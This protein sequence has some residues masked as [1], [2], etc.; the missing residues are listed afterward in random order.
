MRAKRAES[1]YKNDAG[2]AVFRYID[3]EEQRSMTRDYWRVCVGTVIQRD[4]VCVAF[5][6][7]IS[8]GVY[9]CMRSSARSR[10][11][12]YIVKESRSE[13]GEY[14]NDTKAEGGGIKSDDRW[15]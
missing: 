8:Q 13:K 6:V 1:D 15:V 4:V 3:C 5:L 7:V 10:M 11:E 12:M 2:W 14:S 9:I